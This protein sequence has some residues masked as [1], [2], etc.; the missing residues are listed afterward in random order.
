MLALTAITA[1][2]LPLNHQSLQVDLPIARV[3]VD[4][5]VGHLT[6]VVVRIRASQEHL[7]AL[8]GLGI[9]VEP[10]GE[11]WVYQALVTAVIKLESVLQVTST[12]LV[13]HVVERR[14]HV[15]NSQAWVTHPEDTIK[16]G[17]RRKY[18]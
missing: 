13:H 5:D 14:H 6:L 8:L 3:G 17:R 12:H 2:G 9:S 18:T 10:E 11:N 16:P 15:E 4:V 7:S 1:H